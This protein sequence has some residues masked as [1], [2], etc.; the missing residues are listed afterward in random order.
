M[1]LILNINIC[2]DNFAGKP[3]NKSTIWYNIWPAEI[4]VFFVSIFFFV[5][6]KTRNPTDTI[7]NVLIYV[8]H[9]ICILKYESSLNILDKTLKLRLQ[10]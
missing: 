6:G 4:G 9:N 1:S 3:Q 2:D 10:G 5:Q 8:Y 7:F